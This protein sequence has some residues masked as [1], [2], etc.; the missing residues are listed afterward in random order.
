MNKKIITGDT[1]DVDLLVESWF[2][3]LKKDPLYDCIDFKSIGCRYDEKEKKMFV[4][5]SYDKKKVEEKKKLIE[6]KMAEGVKQ[7]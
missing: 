2:L 5:Y 6:K 3:L 7:K 4:E 1:N